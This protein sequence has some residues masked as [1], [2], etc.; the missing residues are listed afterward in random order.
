M[1]WKL[2]GRKRNGEETPFGSI[3]C[4][5]NSINDGKKTNT[6]D[7]LLTLFNGKFAKINGWK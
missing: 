2:S 5:K 6:L 3:H 1:V 4:V 7:Q